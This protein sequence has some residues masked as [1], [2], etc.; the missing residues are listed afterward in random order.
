MQIECAA[1]LDVRAGK[2]LGPHT[3]SVMDGRITAVRSGAATDPGSGSDSALLRYPEGVCAPGF[4]DLHTHLTMQTSP[5]SY[6]DGFRSNQADTAYRA[7]SY[8]RITLEAGFTTV[9]DLGDGDNISIALRNAINA[10]LVRGPRIYTSGKSIATTGGHADPTNG[11][12]AE[13]SGDPGPREG[14][15]NSV[16]DARKA[17]RQRYKDGADWIKITATGGVLS[18]AKNGLNPQF[19]QSELNAVVTT[20]LD[21]DL[22][23]AAHAHGTE[24]MRRA[25]EA[26]VTTI[27]HGT[28]MDASLHALMK[29]HGTWYV[30]TLMAGHYVAQQSKIPGYYPEIVR[31]KA[32]SIGPQLIQSFGLAYKAGVKIAFGT[33]A[34][35]FPHGRNAEEFALMVEGGMPAAEALRSATVHA[36]EVLRLSDQLGELAVGRYADLVVLDGDPLRD[37]RA[38][39]RVLAVVKGGVQ[40]HLQSAAAGK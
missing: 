30:P 10:G 35:V 40:E 12:R 25:I 22:P 39:E 20:A 6:S 23:V 2:V 1:L 16:G 19:S 28:Y 3:L 15:I 37:I 36:A 17:V 9:R 31:P 14:V 33:D 21:Y 5:T 38:T 7:Q 29:K 27:E 18:L 8:A 24:G 11:R 13:L 4:I 34:G 32:A 26:G